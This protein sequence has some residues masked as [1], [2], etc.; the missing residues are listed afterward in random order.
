MAAQ[1]L[2]GVTSAQRGGQEGSASSTV[3][4]NLVQAKSKGLAPADILLIYLLTNPSGLFQDKGTVL[5]NR[6]VCQGS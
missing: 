4:A 2:P 5:Q 1:P 6:S 3:Q